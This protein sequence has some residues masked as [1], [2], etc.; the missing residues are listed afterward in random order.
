MFKKAFIIISL[1]AACTSS[2]QAFNFE[3]ITHDYTPGGK[4]SNH[5]FRAS[6]PGDEKIAVK[7]SVRP[8]SIEPDGTELQGDDSDLFMIYPRQMILNPGDSRSIRVKWTG[9]TAPPAEI[10]FRI[11][12]EQ[13]PVSF[14]EIQPFE[15]GQ[16]TLT[17]RYEG[18]IY[19][20]PPGAR[21][22]VSINSVKRTTESEIISETV[23]ETVTRTVSTD[24]GDKE[25]EEEVEKVVETEIS[26]DYLVF[27]IE[28]SGTRHS[29]LNKIEI[30]LKRDENDSNPIILTDNQLK[31]VAGENVL[32]DSIRIFRIPIPAGLWD[33]PVYGSIKQES[34]Y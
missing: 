14:A 24:E 13:V 17:Y 32:A 33:G 1:I 6:N 8:R 3:P 29:L 25:V 31:G 21:P 19:I 22:E 11:I 18:N 9:E 12:A 34:A 30:K 20:V 7:I 15:G 2:V 23:I 27:E 26:T 5:V 16:I 4:G 10:P 28:N